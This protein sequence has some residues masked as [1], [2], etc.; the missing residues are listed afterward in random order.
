MAVVAANPFVMK[1]SVI[2]FAADSY[3]AAVTSATLTPSA[4][5][6]TVTGLKAGAVFSDSTAA[7]WTLDLT[8]MQDW[9]S[10]TS[11][12]RY[13]FTNEGATVAAHI[14]PQIGKIGFDVNVI[15]TPGAIGG[16]VNAYALATVSLGVKGK[17]V[18]V[19]AP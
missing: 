8:F 12:G 10:A 17:P 3:E 7:T 16:A 13:L 5:I 14:K 19:P 1:E 2:T 4:S 18:L 6:Q 11:L 15:I 9:A